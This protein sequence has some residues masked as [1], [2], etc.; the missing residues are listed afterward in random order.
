MA[1]LVP[2]IDVLA[3]PQRREDVDARDKRGHDGGEVD[4]I[5]TKPALVRAD[6]LELRVAIIGVSEEG[7]VPGL[8]N[9]AARLR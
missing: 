8:V 7:R 1:G 9:K 5:R 4:S 3:S 6:E 2:A